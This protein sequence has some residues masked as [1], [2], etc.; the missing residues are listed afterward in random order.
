MLLRH[1]LAHQ[2]AVKLFQQL[3]HDFDGQ[4]NRDAVQI[5]KVVDR[6]GLNRFV[7]CAAFSKVAEADDGIGTGGAH[8]GP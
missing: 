6:R 1:P 4:E 7:E 8:I 2:P 3:E 5:E